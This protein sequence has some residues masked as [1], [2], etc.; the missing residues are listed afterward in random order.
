MRVRL[1]SS[2]LVPFLRGERWRP[3]PVR[4]AC[5]NRFVASRWHVQ[6]RTEPAWRSAMAL[7]R[8]RLC[9]EHS[10][11]YPGSLRVHARHTS[12]VTSDN[13][14]LTGPRLSVRPLCELGFVSGTAIGPAS[15]APA[16]H[17]VH[18]CDVDGVKLRSRCRTSAAWWRF[19]GSGTRSPQIGNAFAVLAASAGPL[20]A[21]RRWSAPRFRCRIASPT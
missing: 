14:F 16:R 12:H 20:G 2:C 4:S 19:M 17:A 15:T 11:R 13:V 18:E 8:P 9:A 10:L 3:R 6:R 21:A 1:P 7:R 5:A